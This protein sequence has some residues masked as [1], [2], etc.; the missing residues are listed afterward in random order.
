[1]KFISPSVL[2]ASVFFIL[3]GL[4]H[5]DGI[6]EVIKK[7]KCIF[8]IS[9]RKTRCKTLQI[10]FVFVVDIKYIEENNQPSTK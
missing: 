5:G 10:Y 6:N 4:S 9:F 7:N 3:I 8:F 1:M 2:V